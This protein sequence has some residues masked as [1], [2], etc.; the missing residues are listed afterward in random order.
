V[1]LPDQGQEIERE[2]MMA[3]ERL[4]AAETE[5][6]R[7]DNQIRQLKDHLQ[8]VEEKGARIDGQ[9]HANLALLQAEKCGVLEENRFLLEQVN[10]DSHYVGERHN[11]TSLKH[12]TCSS[13]SSTHLQTALWSSWPAGTRS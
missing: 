8:N 3:L 1:G 12:H 2:M 9:L 6:H 10:A 7:R 11:D 5:V 13:I 4:A